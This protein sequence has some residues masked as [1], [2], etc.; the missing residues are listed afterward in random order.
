MK[1]GEVVEKGT[2]L[3]LL[4]N[5]PQGIYSELVKNENMDE[6]T[7]QSLIELELQEKSSHKYSLVHSKLDLIT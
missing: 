3:S 7:K 1:Y 5:F 2:H 6:E 4:Q